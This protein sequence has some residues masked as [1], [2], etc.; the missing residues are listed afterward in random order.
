LYFDRFLVLITLIVE[1][2]LEITLQE[3]KNKCAV[4]EK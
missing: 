2:D 1:E 4:L 3:I